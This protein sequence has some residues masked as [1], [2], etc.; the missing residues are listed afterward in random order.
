MTRQRKIVVLR[1]L[2]SRYSW[3][4]HHL[5]KHHLFILEANDGEDLF[6]KVTRDHPDLA[7]MTVSMEKM[8]ATEAA[9]SIRDVEPPLP[10]KLICISDI[11]SLGLEDDARDAGIDLYVSESDAST[12]VVV[13]IKNFLKGNL[14]DGF[15]GSSEDQRQIFSM[16]GSQRFDIE[17]LI[18]YETSQYQGEGDFVNLSR[19]GALFKAVDKLSLGSR[20]KLEWVHPKQGEMKLEGTVVR[21]TRISDQDPKPFLIGAKFKNIDFDTELKLEN[22]LKTLHSDEEKNLPPL[23]VEEVKGILDSGLERIKLIF[24]KQ[25]VNPY[26]EKSVGELSEYER[27]SFVS[28]TDFAKCIQELVAARVKCKVIELFLPHLNEYPSIYGPEII[29]ALAKLLFHMDQTEEYAD[30]LARKAVENADERV[31]NYLNNSSNRLFNGKSKMLRELDRVIQSMPVHSSFARDLEVIK[32]HVKRAVSYDMVPPEVMANKTR[33]SPAVYSPTGAR[34][35]NGVVHSPEAIKKN[36]QKPSSLLVLVAA[37]SV[38]MYGGYQAYVFLEKLVP[39][40][41]YKFSFEPT[42]IER[43]QHR[44]LN[45]YIDRG[46]WSQLELWQQKSFLNEIEILLTKDNLSQAKLMD[47]MGNLLAAVYSS[48]KSQGR[49]LYRSQI[50]SVP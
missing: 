7:I 32:K 35:I 49:K 40:E 29:P 44:G 46:R 6:N 50:F 26:L 13:F 33:Y 21:S 20:M 16:R 34:R 10:T 30:S 9:K 15:E 23:T 41:Q 2:L 36:N 27:G 19:G 17:G 1:E 18:S 3:L 37:L 39:K 11:V 25:D 28:K 14:P 4:E 8:T 45:F 22:I 12:R 43:E 31:R 47:S 48:Q 24:E 38:I 42:R 5:E